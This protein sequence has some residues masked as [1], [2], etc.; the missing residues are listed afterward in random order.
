MPVSWSVLINAVGLLGLPSSPVNG[1]ACEL[2]IHDQPVSRV[3][4]SQRDHIAHRHI[5]GVR[6][7]AISCSHSRKPIVGI[8][9]HRYAKEV[10]KHC[11][12]RCAFLGSGW[13]LKHVCRSQYNTHA[14][15]FPGR[16]FRTGRHQ[17]KDT[18]VE[19][20]QAV[21]KAQGEES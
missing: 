8:Y 19:N 17:E 1:T 5:R 11:V 10:F 13:Y 21:P 16:T 2:I 20:R 3:A 7:R 4:G 12:L 18:G 6:P 9:P 15:N 14:Q